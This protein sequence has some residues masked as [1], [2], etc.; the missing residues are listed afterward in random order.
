MQPRSELVTCAVV[1]AGG[2]GTRVGLGVPKQLIKV[3][4]KSI[5]EHT[6]D[7][8]Q[9]S[10][11]I[12]EIHIV[13]SAPWIDTLAS[14]LGNR[15]SKLRNILPGGGTRNDSTRAALVSL[16]D[17][18]CKVLFHDAVRPFVDERILFDCVT[19][20]DY[21]DAVDVVIESADTIVE[22]SE[23]DAVVG[24]PD[25][26]RLRRGQTPQGFLLSTIR[27]AYELAAANNFTGATDDCGVVLRFMPETRIAAVKGSEENIKITRPL[28]LITADRLF[29]LASHTLS[30]APEQN[31]RALAG[32][33]VVIFGGSYGIGYAVSRGAEQ[34]G[35]N[36]ESFSRSKT[37][38]DIRDPEGI[39]RA[40][41]QAEQASGRIDAVV[42]AAA[43]LT[44]AALMELT[45]ASL[46][47]QVEVNLLSPALIAKAAGPYLEKTKGHLVF[48]TS[49]SYTRGRAEYSLYSAAKAGVVNLTQAL[50]DEWSQ[51]GI[52][53]NCINPERTDTPM[54]RSAFGDEP[55][56]SLLS[57]T[58]VAQTVLD[59]ILSN[60]T[61]LVVDVRRETSTTH[62]QVADVADAIETG[63]GR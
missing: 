39:E 29:Q 51:L 38:T 63:G 36:V 15:Y 61:G 62:Q 16:G 41:A 34:L 23:D 37:Q 56:E 2:T 59:L 32:K 54:R 60:Y 57:A 3:A 55:P 35:A 8:L 25:R 28:D 47:E 31:T 44:K 46:I 9:A 43:S 48:F 33:T 53:V 4:G 27:K 22:I 21:H 18:E 6:L 7:C 50:A 45:T 12:D 26:S 42:I 13:M 17:R 49:S 52:K 20:L 14:M 58:T 1:L 19:A 30:P 11:F 40:L 5:I 24:I 10:E